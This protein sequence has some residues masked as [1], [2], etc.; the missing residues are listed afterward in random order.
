MGAVTRI[1][2][3]RHG[4]STW[5]V[6][7]RL[8]GQ[9]AHPELT[10]RGREQAAQ[11]AEELARRV[12]GRPAAVWSSDLVRAAQTAQAVAQRLGVVVRVEPAL[13]EQGLGSM[14]GRL[15][16]ELEPQEVPAGRHVTEVRWG[17]GESIADVHARLTALA[18]RARADVPAGTDFVWVT[19]GDT[20]RVALAVLT[21]QGHRDVSWEGVVA[22]G[23]V[24]TVEVDAQPVSR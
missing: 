17:G 15:T 3:V 10:A 5:N 7:R 9:T 19:H 24:V 16:R 6:E 1:H 4:E 20:L 8:Q 12:G 22:N 2:L 11:A 13:R 14:E 18:A 23:A 21:G